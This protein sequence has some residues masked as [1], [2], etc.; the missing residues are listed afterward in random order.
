MRGA[1]IGFSWG[2]TRKHFIR[3]VLES[4]G[5]EYA[6]YL[7]I[8]RGLAPQLDLIG[9]RVIGGGAKSEAWNQIKAGAQGMRDLGKRA[10]CGESFWN[11]HRHSSSG[12]GSGAVGRK[13]DVAESCLASY[14]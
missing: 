3:A 5:Y 13:V 4:I 6:W 1:W 14:L 10:D 2:H 11:D 7:R 12:N 8:L 9:A